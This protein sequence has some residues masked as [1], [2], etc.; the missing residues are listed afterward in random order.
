MLIYVSLSFKHFFLSVLAFMPISRFITNS[1][2]WDGKLQL[3]IMCRCM[4]IT[5]ITLYQWFGIL[6]VMLQRSKYVHENSII[7]VKHFKTNNCFIKYV[8]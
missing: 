1:I 5:D 2:K 8:L 6:L 7:K 3:Y 4:H